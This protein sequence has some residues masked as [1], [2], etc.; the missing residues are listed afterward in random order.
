MKVIKEIHVVLV[1]VLVI[2]Y[3]VLSAPMQLNEMKGFTCESECNGNFDLCVD[4]S[5]NIE[6]HMVCIK[7]NMDC[8]M[9]CSD[10]VLHFLKAK[11]SA[12]TAYVN[13]EDIPI[14]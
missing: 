3:D 4:A 14:N 10:L 7:S 13:S 9:K 1:V 8:H 2:T 6:D 5:M 12:L 11:K